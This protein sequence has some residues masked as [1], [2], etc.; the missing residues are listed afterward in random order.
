MPAAINPVAGSVSNHEAKIRLTMGQ[1]VSASL[2]RNPTPAIEPVTVWVVETGTPS[3]V[4]IKIT[5]AAPASAAEPRIEFKGVIPL[6]RTCAIR[7]P[8]HKV[9]RLM[10]A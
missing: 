7:K 3:S 6:P 8:P 10:T 1:W 9:P 4:A 5:A 2:L